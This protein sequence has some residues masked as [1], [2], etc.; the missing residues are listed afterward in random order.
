MAETEV[1]ISTKGQVVIPKA[2]RDAMHWKAGQKLV[3]EQVGSR[4]VIR[5]KPTAKKHSIREVAGM[6]SEYAKGRP[7]TESEMSEAI[8]RGIADEYRKSMK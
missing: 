2:L 8:G 1:S 5:E 6:L 7:P 4:V 3:I